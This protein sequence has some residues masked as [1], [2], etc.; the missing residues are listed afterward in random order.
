M[1]T[2][3]VCLL[4]LLSYSRRGFSDCGHVRR[5]G[6]NKDVVSGIEITNPGGNKTALVV[7]QTGLTS[8]PKDTSYAFANGLAESGW[9]VEIT[10]AS[11]QA[12]SDLS[13]EPSGFGLSD[14]WGQS[15]AG[16]RSLR[17][18]G[19]GLARD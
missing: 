15:G 19:G 4:C 8:F 5:F 6:V 12:P 13:K 3:V 11:L 10:I 18:Q 16:H 14:L 2:G 17:R 1:E 9:R 7:Y